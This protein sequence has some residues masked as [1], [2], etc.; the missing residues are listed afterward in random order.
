MLLSLLV[1]A[2][3]QNVA[4]PSPTA[5]PDL[6]A[7]IQ[8]AQDGRNAEALA[9]L[10][11]IVAA[12]PEDHTARL[13]IASVHA[14]M[15]HPDVAEAVYHSVVLEDP[16]NVDAWV[17]LG[18]VLL[19]QDRVVEGLDALRRAE[20][21]SPENPNVV[22][23]LADGYRLAGE[24]TQSISYYQRLTVLAPTITNRITLENARRQHEHR[25]E[26]Q[27]YG[28]DY[29]GVTPA[30]RGSDL[31][32]NY[33]L[34]EP[35]RLIGRAQLQTKADRRENRAGGGV[36]WRYTPWGTVTGQV[37]VGGDNR[38]MPQNDF[39]GR[40]EYGYHRATYTGTL[41]YFDFFG[42]NVVMFA[43]G[44]TVSL[45]PRWTVGGRYAFTSTD[46]ATV[47][48]IKGQTLDLRAAHELRPRIW[49]RGGYVSGVDNFDLYSIDQIGE[50][51][52]KTATVGVQLLLPSLTAIVANY[53]YQWR[54]NRVTPVSS[55]S[56]PDQRMWRIN[57]GL[58]Q[59]F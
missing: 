28:E 24:Q 51:R 8:L 49:L 13:W 31:A 7:A 48:G 42:A 52:A 11:K 45:T 39:L 26:S 20:Q 38:V 23:S 34:S 35:V 15:G 14:R 1:L 44:A 55:P 29:N 30:T 57:V 3:A 47:T 46:T 18:N 53:D 5:P 27:T 9:A 6:P 12:N 19:Q 22:A 33:R 17:G 40:V 21:L 16:G 43:P 58:V 2:L 25:F 59:A 32:L 36:E 41:R 56:I 10:Q 4:Q 54:G 37:L 50:F